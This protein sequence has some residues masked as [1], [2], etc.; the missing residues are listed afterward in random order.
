M[1]LGDDSDPNSLAISTASSTT[2]LWGSFLVLNKSSQIAS[3]KVAR[4]TGA[5]WEIGQAGA[6]WIINLSIAFWCSSTL[7]ACE[8]FGGWKPFLKTFSNKYLTSLTRFKCLGSLFVFIILSTHQRCNPTIGLW[9]KP[10]YPL[11]WMHVVPCRSH[12]LDMCD[13]DISDFGI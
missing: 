7:P 12:S 4:S 11:I 3:L 8:F 2:T 6:F 10:F 13:A 5:I 1:N 9:F